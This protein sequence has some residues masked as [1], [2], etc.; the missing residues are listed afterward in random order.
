MWSHPELQSGVHIDIDIHVVGR[1]GVESNRFDT[2]T[3]A[4]LTVGTGTI[5]PPL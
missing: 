4:T 3:N 2:F 5:S 1:G